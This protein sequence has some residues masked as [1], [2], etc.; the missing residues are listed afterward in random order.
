MGWSGRREKGFVRLRKQKGDRKRVGRGLW[1]VSSRSSDGTLWQVGGGGAS[2][3]GR[4]LGRPWGRVA[5]VYLRS[6]S[7]SSERSNFGFEWGV[8][9]VEWRGRSQKRSENSEPHAIIRGAELPFASNS[10]LADPLTFGNAVLG[11]S[12]TAAPPTSA[13]RRT[14]PCFLPHYFTVTSTL[15]TPVHS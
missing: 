4:G 1:V 2:R 12:R 13:S 11:P 15:N 10:A 14:D 7:K 3:F 5:R 9:R 6:K 8:M